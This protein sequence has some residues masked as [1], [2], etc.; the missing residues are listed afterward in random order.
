MAT[1]NN[2][3]A[4]SPKTD[5]TS[6][7]GIIGTSKAIQDVLERIQKV[8]C[9]DVSVLIIGE[10]G[11]GKE[12]VARLIHNLSNRQSDIFIPVNMG[13]VAPEL[14]SSEI[15]GH[16]KGSFTGAT[17]S[18]DGLFATANDG[19][20]FLDEVGSMDRKTQTA[21]LRIL[22]NRVFRKVGG[23]KTY[24]TNARILAANDTDLRQAVKE[25][26]FRRDLLYRLEVFSIHVPPLR[27]RCEDIPLLVEHFISL[28]RNEM[29]STLV[30]SLTNEALESLL[31]YNWPG[32]I[33]ELKNAIQS[34]M[35]LTEGKEITLDDLPPRICGRNRDNSKEAIPP[36]LPLKEVEKI[37]I[38]QTLKR[39]NGNKSAAAKSLGVSRRYLYNKIE[40][41]AI[42][43]KAF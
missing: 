29:E 26:R 28:F 13:A 37:Y 32:N 17:D 16:V 23:R 31:Q 27:E 8:A 25:K 30:N 39:T 36:G 35:L 14:V 22:E 21:L 7:N 12:L 43:C 9:E 40:E 33:R 19:T 2:K 6:F 11:T 41:Y 3:K 42:D 10:T 34:A 1:G 5:H 24:T 38:T 20:L 4:A 15:F 18:R